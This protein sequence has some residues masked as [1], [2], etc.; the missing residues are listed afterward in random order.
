[1]IRDFLEGIRS[2]GR[3]WDMIRT[4]RLWGYFLVPALISVVLGIA[5]GTS[6][7]ALSDNI[8]AWIT[9]WLPDGWGGKAVGT[10]GR[11]L[12]GLLVA[13][14]GL[15]LFKTLVLIL[16]APFMSP[17][18][19]KIE[20]QLTGASFDG[21]F[22]PGQM[23]RDM[24]RGIRINVRNLFWEL[25]LSLLLVIAGAILPFLSPLVPLL[26]FLV[27]AY[28]AG[29]GNMDYTLERHFGYRDSILFVREFRGM[30]LGNGTVYLLL[31]LTGVGFLFALPL[32]TVAA[33]IDSAEQIRS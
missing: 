4:H 12:A 10:V 11:I 28:Y 33:T 32:G 16:G 30:A 22:R 19:E 14:G 26:I 21:G 29:F 2:Y 9:G 18:S 8:S 20:A 23:V 3:A 17:L 1:M 27:Q 31:L 25:L 13:A 7:W 6:A 5:I 24:V 15:A